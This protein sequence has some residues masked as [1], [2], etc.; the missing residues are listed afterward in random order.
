MWAHIRKEEEVLFPFIVRMEEESILAYPPEHACFRSVSHP[1]LM[2]VQEHEAA[3]RI[4]EK[5][6][7]S[8]GNFSV[9]GWACPTHRA[10]LEGLRD[11][12][13]DLQ[14]HIHLENDILFPRS[15]QME[16]ELRGK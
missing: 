6:R 3:N 8:T 10:L 16:A 11:F 7:S 5:I 9:P 1:V 13:A 4:M 15:I 2:M 12:D 14:Q